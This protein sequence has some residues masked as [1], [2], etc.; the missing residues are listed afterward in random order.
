MIVSSVSFS[1]ILTLLRKGEE[2]SLPVHVA[3][4][5]TKIG[6]MAPEKPHL[7]RMGTI[8]CILDILAPWHC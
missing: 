6:R 4:L 8:K 1:S 5:V 2:R 7:Y 3:E